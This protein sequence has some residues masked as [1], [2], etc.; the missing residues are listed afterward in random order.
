MTHA[1]IGRQIMAPTT[2]RESTSGLLE[3]TSKV[4]MSVA[5]QYAPDHI[6]FYFGVMLTS[7]QATKLDTGTSMACAHVAGLVACLLATG[8]WIDTT[9][10]MKAKLKE[11]SRKD[12][13]DSTT[14]KLLHFNRKE[15]VI[16]ALLLTGYSVKGSVNYLAAQHILNS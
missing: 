12:K 13:L 16:E 1:G 8:G 6:I 9:E 11:Y 7:T 14:R 3:R 10:E 2:G 4:H 15:F 5:K